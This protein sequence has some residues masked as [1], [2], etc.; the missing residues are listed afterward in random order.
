MD[1]SDPTFDFCVAGGQRYRK[2][3]LPDGFDPVATF[4]RPGGRG[5][6]DGD[7]FGVGGDE[8]DGH[9]IDFAE[10]DDG[11]WRYDER[12]GR[13]VY[14]LP[15]AAVYYKFLIGSGRKK[16]MQMQQESNSEIRIPPPPDKIDCATM[17]R[18]SVHCDFSL[19]DSD[20]RDPVLIN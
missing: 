12:D 18:R 5:N 11:R 2:V 13:Y 10:E 14:E 6:V 4:F 16:L 3:Q 17:G 19:S 8:D 7:G 15:V 1:W 9:N 20:H